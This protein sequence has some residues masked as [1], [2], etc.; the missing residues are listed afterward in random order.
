M[1]FGPIRIGKSIG[2]V[3]SNTE[4]DHLINEADI[5]RFI[6]VQRIKCL[7]HI[8]RMDTSRT[9]KRILEWKPMGRRPLGRPKRRWSDDV[10]AES[11][12]LEGISN[13]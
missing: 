11:E 1:I 6:K 5:V 3:R 4:L 9:A 8:Q 2:R 10:C 12:K 13:G 7:G